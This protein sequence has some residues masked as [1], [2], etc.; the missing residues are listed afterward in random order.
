MKRFIYSV[1]CAS[2]A[3]L[4]FVSCS[5]ESSVQSTSILDNQLLTY[6]PNSSVG[7]VT[8]D[9]QSASYKRLKESAW[10]KNMNKSYEMFKKLE[11]EA[12]ESDKKVFRIIDSLAVTGI[13]PKSA[14]E[15]EAIRS[16]MIYFDIDTVKKVPVAGL[17]AVA[18]DGQNLQEKLTTIE[19]VLNKEGVKTN[20]ETVG[21]TAGFSIDIE[22]AKASGAPIDKIYAVASKDKLALGTSTEAITKFL[23]GTADGGI[24]KIKDSNEFKQA[25]RGIVSAGDSMTFAFI[26]FNK[27]VS[28]LD[29]I[30]KSTGVDTGANELKEV[31]VES[32]ALASQMKDSLSNTITVSLSPRND[33]QKQVIASFGASG[34]NDIIKRVPSDIMLLL[35]IDGGTISSI[36]KTALAQI[37]EEAYA[38]AK[39][40]LNLLDS[41]KT[42]A[43][44]VRAAAGA[45]PFPEV[46]LVAESSQAPEI[47]KNVKAQL[48]TAL[49]SSGMPLPWQ[50]KDVGET[51]V[52]Y[53]LSPFG[54]G[55]YL[56]STPDLVVLST[57]E[58]LVSDMVQ[59]SKNDSKGLLANLSQSSKDTVNNSKSIIVAYTDF[60]KIGNTLGSVQ[61]SLS[62]F[63]GGKAS[64]QREQIE[65]IKQIGTVMLSLNLEDNLV[66]LQ[67]NYELPPQPAS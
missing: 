8:W 66:K 48:D 15:Q 27:L 64:I 50:Q 12:A 55:A 41:I 60:S 11:T 58:K 63:T 61:D 25:T 43:I 56:T 35:S 32:F 40:L 33:M 31:P 14:S 38:E 54:V 4:T 20:K 44:G 47:E 28:S 57:G 6:L 67:S 17:F 53:A 21:S 29:S 3:C 13:W 65:Q 1:V 5:K 10:G 46:L 19:G 49:A 7:F 52:T 39:S 34:K 9:T 42:V 45:S 22:G 16:A 26:D 24:Q 36:K 18:A 59:S 2:I 30:A 23:S 51:K 62:M 37:P